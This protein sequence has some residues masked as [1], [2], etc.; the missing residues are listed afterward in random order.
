M[1]RSK[2][3]GQMK[4]QLLVI[5]DGVYEIIVGVKVTEIQYNC[6]DKQHKRQEWQKLVCA[7]GYLTG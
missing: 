2:I 1:N 3:N 4:K 6:Y 7:L 5:Q